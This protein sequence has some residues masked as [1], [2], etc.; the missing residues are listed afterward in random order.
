MI[1]PKLFK[2]V[3]CEVLTAPLQA[4]FETQVSALGGPSLAVLSLLGLPQ[5][6]R[7]ILQASPCPHCSQGSQRLVPKYTH[8]PLILRS[9]GQAPSPHSSEILEIGSSPQALSFQEPQASAP[10]PQ[11]TLRQAPLL[12][13]AGPSSPLSIKTFSHKS[14]QGSQHNPLPLSLFT[15]TLLG[16]PPTPFLLRAPGS[17]LKLL[18]G[19]SAIPPDRSPAPSLISHRLQALQKMTLLARALSLSPH[20]SV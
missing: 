20:P 17:R 11:E 12:T 2:E 4:L 8:P 5:S 7:G 3:S 16:R 9:L 18:S 15:E 6:P 19:T 14:S 1:D 13:E 10:I